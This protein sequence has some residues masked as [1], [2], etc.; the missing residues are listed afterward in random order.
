MRGRQAASWMKRLCLTGSYGVFAAVSDRTGRRVS[1][2]AVQWE[3]PSWDEEE[4]CWS[5]VRQPVLKLKPSWGWGLWWLPSERLHLLISWLG[6][7]ST[8]EVTLRHSV[9]VRLCPTLPI[10]A[11]VAVQNTVPHNNWICLNISKTARFTR[12]SKSWNEVR[13]CFLFKFNSVL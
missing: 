10:Q 7:S 3:G 8:D 11:C 6:T 4:K 9:A 12:V 13:T 2:K 1:G 5:I